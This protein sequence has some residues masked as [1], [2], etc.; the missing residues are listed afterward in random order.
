MVTGEVILT[1]TTITPWR[2]VLYGEALETIATTGRD[3]F[4]IEIVQ[5]LAGRKFAVTYF[6]IETVFGA[7]S[8]P[9]M[10]TEYRDRDEVA[11]WTDR[12]IGNR[13]NAYGVASC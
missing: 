4:T 7:I 11:A 13:I 3:R 8:E 12:V 2:M 9:Y 6:Q 1:H 5:A 10:R